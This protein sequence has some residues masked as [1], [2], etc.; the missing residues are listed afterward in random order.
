[1]L[2]LSILS[3]YHFIVRTKGSDMHSVFPT[4]LA[5]G[6]SLGPGLAGPGPPIGRIGFVPAA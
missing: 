2:L 3:I 5:Y 4:G 6:N 1:M